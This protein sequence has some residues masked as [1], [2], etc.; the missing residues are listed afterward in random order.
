MSTVDIAKTDGGNPREFDFE[1]PGKFLYVGNRQTNQV[2]TFA[3]DPDTGKMTPTGA[4]I[5]MPK[6]ACVKFVSLWPITA[7]SPDLR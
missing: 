3:V 7:R 6:P 4:K 5:E 2:V 1:P